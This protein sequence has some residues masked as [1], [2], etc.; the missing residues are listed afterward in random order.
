MLV[1]A[2]PVYTIIV[3]WYIAFPK[4]SGEGESRK[5]GI[6]IFVVG[7]GRHTG[8]LFCVPVCF[9]YLLKLQLHSKLELFFNCRRTC[10]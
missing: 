10:E 8:Q 5:G 3:Q 9:F 4:R 1:F 7:S 2:F 6:Q